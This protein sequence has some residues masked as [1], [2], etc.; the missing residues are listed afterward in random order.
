ME[1]AA[2]PK[3]QK[4]VDTGLAIAE[5]DEDVRG[6][7]AVDIDGQ[8]IGEVDALYIDEAARKVRYLEVKSGGFLGIGASTFLM[9]V[10]AVK[11]IDENAVRVDRARETL[12][13]APTYQPELVDKPSYWE[14]VSRYYGYTP[15]WGAGYIYPAFPFYMPP[16][17]PPA[18]EER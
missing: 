14:E 13:R 15:F 6:R 17:V 11:D 1:Q 9:P 10:D 3:L 16:P 2:I 5:P 4:L 7:K 8:E 12:D 18:E